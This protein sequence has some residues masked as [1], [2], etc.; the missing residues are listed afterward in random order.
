MANCVQC[1][2]R[3]PPLSWKKT[4]EWCVRH[5]AAQRGEE[6]EDAI[7]P[8]MAAPWVRSSGLPM[9]F[10]QVI[11]GFNVVIFVAMVASGISPTNPTSQ[12]LIQWGA[13]SGPLTLGG[14]WWRLLSCTFLH[15]GVIHLGFNMWCLWDLGA[16]CES[17]YGPWTFAAMYLICGL[18]GS[19]ASVA[20]NPHVISAG[21]SGAIFGLAGA[22]LASL[23]LG[24][25]SLPRSALSCTYRSLTMFVGYNLL[26]GAVS[27]RTDNAAHVGGLVTGLVLGA[28]IARAAPGAD[29]PFPR[30]AILL[31]VL[32]AVA[33]GAMWVQHARAFVVHQQRGMEFLS[34]RN[35]D[36][37]LSELQAASRQSPKDAYTHY[38]LAHLYTLKSDYRNAESE[39]QH[40]IELEPGNEDA[41]YHLGFTYLEEKQSSKARDV[42]TKLLS[43]NRTSGEA[44]Y[45]LGAT[46]AFEQNYTLAVQEYSDAARLNP[47]LDG[48]YYQIGFCQLKQRKYDE[49]IA[50]LQQARELEQDDSATELA[51]ADAYQA[52]GMQHEADE[53]RH[54]A[55]QMKSR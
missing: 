10:T 16:L 20:W 44:H 23:R 52:K 34:Q 30:M 12:Q 41:L 32:G 47:E 19:V 48:V 43:I 17:L 38:E 7:Q 46:A 13:N 1:G 54:K 49:A 26:F 24:E 50:A 14:Q 5:E 45:G 31:G 37:A 3:L 11:L 25:F 22:L 39:L 35:F 6:R 36:Q 21:A 33:G 8:V 2:R 28:L 55:E 42:F 9:G 18:G 4:C 27:G 29:N 51:L 15:I 53:A 40:V